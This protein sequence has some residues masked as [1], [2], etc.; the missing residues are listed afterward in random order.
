MKKPLQ[1]FVAAGGGA[2]NAVSF[3][4][5]NLT[6]AYGGADK[7][8]YVD[9]IS[10][11][12]SQLADEKKIHTL[13]IHPN[14]A[15]HFTAGEDG[16]VKAWDANGAPI[17]AFAGHQGPVKSIAVNPN[18]QQIATGGS[19]KKLILWNF[20]DP[21]KAQYIITTPSEV[22]QI[23]YSKDQKKLLAAGSD[24]L[25]RGYTP[26]LPNPPPAQPPS[27]DPIQVTDGHTAAVTSLAFL[28]DNKTALSAG[29]DG[30][31]KGW[32]VALAAATATLAGHQSQVYSLALH[33][34][35]P[36]LASVSNDKTLK[37]WNLENNQ[38]T[39]TSPAQGGAIYSCLYTADGQFLLT[40]GAD[41]SVRLYNSNDGTQVRQYAGAEDA[42]YTV[43]LSPNG[44]QV[45]GAGL[46][47]KIFLWDFNS[48]QLAKTLAGHKDDIYRVEFNPAGTRLMSVGYAGNLHIWDPAKDAPIY[49]QKLPAI[50]YSAVYAPGGKH[51][52]ALTN[53]GKV[54]L[55]DIP[56]EAQ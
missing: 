29:A 36:Q 23:A 15:I 7:T 46:Q 13:C 27:Q 48:G 50:A 17:R 34:T 16:Q 53:D 6:L 31:V 40:C 25:I 20:N 19:D 54:Y 10:V 1:H 30:A 22:V 47:R 52:V 39:F 11:Q 44:Q 5:D 28:A 51:F 9:G 45:A 32:S 18:Q 4:V 24:N 41:K 43:A 55:Y 33:P 14:S 8:V 2:L 3:G 42:L 56:A 49:S 12:L 37:F 21:S 35:K 26:E 38:P